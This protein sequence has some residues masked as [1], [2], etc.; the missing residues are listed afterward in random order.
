MIEED[1]NDRNSTDKE[2]ALEQSFLVEAEGRP[3]WRQIFREA[4]D[5]ARRGHRPAN[6]SGLGRDHSRSLVLLAGA[7]IAVLLLFLAVFSSPNHRGRPG[8]TS[9]QRTPNLGQRTTPGQ[10]SAGGKESAVPLLSARADRPPSADASEVTASDVNNT[11]RPIRPSFRDPLKTVKPSVPEGNNPYA[12]GRIDLSDIDAREVPS[13]PD[14]SIRQESDDLRKPSLVFVRNAQEALASG[15]AGAAIEG[16]PEDALNRLELP[17]GTRLVARL[18]SVVT[19]EVRAP[20]IAAIEYNYER[21]GQIVI[22]A[23]ARALGSLQQAGRSGEVDIRFGSLQMPDGTT[24]KIDATAMSLAYGPLQGKVHG[25]KSGGNF[26]IRAVTGL[27]EAATYLVGAGGLNAPLS[28]SALLRDRIATNI[29]IAGD[30]ELN[31]LSLN[32]N[33]VVTIPANTRFF[34]VIGKDAALSGAHEQVAA[35]QPAT[36]LST[37]SIDELRQLLQL[38]QEI[39]AMYQQPGNAQGAAQQPAQP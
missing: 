33:I 24:E 14:S 7:V 5:K 16:E 4:F 23:G 29:G 36:S 17:V 31:S 9:P 21:D 30:Q 25:S 22:P 12:L 15:N 26:L 19:T 8:S 11:A 28:E 1:K 32:Q 35:N 37:P 20:V 18:Q 39:D 34:I 13:Q 2:E 38:R 6:R 10:P 3:G 27:G